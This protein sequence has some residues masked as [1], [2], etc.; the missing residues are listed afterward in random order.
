MDTKNFNFLDKIIAK[1]RL[2]N[3]I[4]FVDKDDKILD[5]GCGSTSFLL[6]NIKSKIKSGVGID[7]DVN[8]RKEEN[9]EYIRFKFDKKLPFKDGSFDKIFMLAVLEHIDVDKV[10]RLF[11]DFKRILKKGG[12]IVLTTPTPASKNLLEFLAFKLKIISENEIRDHKKYYDKR[13][14]LLLTRR[15]KLVLQK[16][17]LFLFNLNSNAVLQKSVK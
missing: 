10:D 12:K 9:I 3:V 4:S 17:K 1:I 2:G 5:F 7:Y 6:N 13:E 11:T 8:N 15:S 14:I 16:Y